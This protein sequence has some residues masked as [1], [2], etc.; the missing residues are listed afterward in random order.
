MKKIIAACLVLLSLVSL[1]PKEALAGAST[2][3]VVIQNMQFSPSVVQV[4]PG[5]VVAWVNNDSVTHTS[6]ADDM[7]S[8]EGW[9]SANLNAGQSFSKTFSKPGTYTYH[10]TTHPYMKGTIQVVAAGQTAVTTQTITVVPTPVATVIPTPAPVA[11]LPRTGFPTE[12]YLLIGLMPFALKFINFKRVKASS[13]ETAR[14][15]WEKRQFKIRF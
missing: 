12:A 14:T 1:S 8:G 11:Q 3:T 9:D 2:T 7:N 10:C 13:I 15:L 6:T 5:T 4:N